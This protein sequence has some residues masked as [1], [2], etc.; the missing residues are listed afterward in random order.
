MNRRSGKYVH[1]LLYPK[2]TANTTLVGTQLGRNNE[3]MCTG[4]GLYLQA[5][6]DIGVLKLLE[7]ETK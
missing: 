7:K 6:L 2:V 3:P 4:C 5:Y 1:S